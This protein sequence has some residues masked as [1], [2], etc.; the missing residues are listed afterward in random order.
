MSNDYSH[1]ST[2]VHLW[3]CCIC[4]KQILDENSD[5]IDLLHKCNLFSHQYDGSSHSIDHTSM[6]RVCYAIFL[7]EKISDETEIVHSILCYHIDPTSCR[8]GKFNCQCNLKIRNLLTHMKIRHPYSFCSLCSHIYMVIYNHAKNVKSV[9]HSGSL[10]IVEGCFV[11]FCKEARSEISIEHVPSRIIG[12]NS[13]SDTTD[14]RSLTGV[15]LGHK[16]KIASITL[17][18]QKY[19]LHEGFHVLEELGEGSKG[20]VRL[21]CTE[22]GELFAIKT[23]PSKLCSDISPTSNEE[24]ILSSL[25]HANIVQC[26]GGF[27]LC[28]KNVIFLEYAHCGILYDLIEFHKGLEPF[29]VLF[30]LRQLASAISYLHRQNILHRDIKAENVLLFNAGYTCKLTDFSE[31]TYINSYTGKY[32]L[33]KFLVY[34]RARVG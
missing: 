24:S 28:D 16:L 21:A 33:F 8:L 18:A 27:E 19:E 4:K 6:H 3:F 10:C 32:Y 5:D 14:F 25:N 30:Y 7:K 11:P 15:F 17:T 12:Y 9:A 20:T 1:K 31:A 2:R 23:L 26:Y 22:N 13:R 34:T 29:Q